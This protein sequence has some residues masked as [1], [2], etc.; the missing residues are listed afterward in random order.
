MSEKIYRWL[1]YLYPKQFRREYGPALLQLFRDRFRAE[2]GLFAHLRFWLDLIVDLA[3]SVPGEHLR[4]SRANADE[5]RYCLSENALTALFRRTTLAPAVLFYLFTILGFSVAR[6]ANA[7]PNLLLIVYS[8]LAIGGATKLRGIRNFRQRWRTFEIVIE[9]ECI[10]QNRCG[11]EMRLSRAAVTEIFEE[12]HGLILLTSGA[13][14]MFIPSQLNGYEEVRKHLNHWMPVKRHV[15]P[16]GANTLLLTSGALPLHTAMLL[17]PVGV[18]LL[19]LAMIYVV[20]LLPI[21]FGLRPIDPNRTPSPRVAKS[22]RPAS[23]QV[24]AGDGIIVERYVPMYWFA[25]LVLSM[26]PVAKCL[27]VLVAHAAR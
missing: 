24:R 4:T 18:W 26:F 2:P 27:I 7:S 3:R 11:R 22:A 6:L 20:C 12:E 5:R 25:F 23:V 9:A 16:N 13:N 15:A 1:L 10:Q 17:V 14:A 8:T 21:F 19:L